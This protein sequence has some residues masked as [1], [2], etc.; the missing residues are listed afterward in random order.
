V[1]WAALAD[2]RAQ[3]CCSVPNASPPAGNPFS[4]SKIQKT[5]K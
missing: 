4:F 2:R 3:H 1:G 5:F